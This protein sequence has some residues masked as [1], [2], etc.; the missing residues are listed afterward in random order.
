MR[1]HSCL[2]IKEWPVYRGKKE[3]SIGAI[4]MEVQTLDLLDK[5]FPNN[6]R[7]LYLGLPWWSGGQVVKTPCSQCRGHWF[8]PWLGN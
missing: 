5:D 4:P 8:N 2:D 7:K 3:Q 1:H 6:Y